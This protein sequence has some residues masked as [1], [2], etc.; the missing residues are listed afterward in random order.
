MTARFGKH[1]IAQWL[2]N[3]YPRLKSFMPD[4]Y[5]AFRYPGGR[6]YWNP[7]NSRGMLARVLGMYENQKM[8]A[9]VKLLRPGS[10]FIDVG[11]NVGDFSLLAASVVGD[12]GKVLC[13]EPEPR[14]CYWLKRSIGLN[15]YENVTV[16]ELA[17]SDSDGEAQLY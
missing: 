15:R 13:F 8:D 14:N 6:I 12:G 17:L 3:H 1:T 11:A 4:R 5:F 9:V 7:K 10:T 16:F 2:L